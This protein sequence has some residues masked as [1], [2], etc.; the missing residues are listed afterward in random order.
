MS[1]FYREKGFS[2]VPI[3]TLF[4]ALLKE[5]ELG[6]IPVPRRDENSKKM[7]NDYTTHVKMQQIFENDARGVNTILFIDELYV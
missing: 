4:G 5:G 1:V 3:V 7:I 2:E 6:G